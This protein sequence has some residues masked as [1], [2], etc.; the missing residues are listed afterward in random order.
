MSLRTLLTPIISS[1]MLSR[2]RLLAHRIK[3]ESARAKAGK[4]HVVRVYLQVDD[5]YSVLLAQVLPEFLRRYPVAVQLSLVSPPP[6]GAAPERD[7][8]VAYS[9]VDSQL[10]ARRHGLQFLDHG[11][12]PDAVCLQHAARQLLT[13]IERGQ[14]VAM[15]A[16][17]LLAAW[18]MPLD[19]ATLR[20][21]AETPLATEPALSSH[22]QAA[23]AERTRLGHY[24]GAT[25]HYEGEWY[26]GIDRL[27][28]LEARLEQLGL[29]LPED[30]QPGM[31]PRVVPW[32]PLIPP[33][34]DVQNP[35]KLPAGSP[36]IEF[37]LSFRSPY[38][39]IVAP[40]VFA[41]AERFGVQV[42][43]RFVLPMV[44][45][46][47]PVPKE[48][49]QYIVRDTA[50][51]AWLQGTDFGRLN[52]PVGK[53]TERG[54]SLIPWAE[55]QG[56]GREYVLAFMDLVW[57][58]GVDAGSNRGL[59]RIVRTAGLNWDEAK[60]ALHNDEWRARAE[61]NRS[62]LFE[63]GLWGVPSFRWGNVTAWGQDR[64]WVLE[65]AMLSSGGGS[66]GAQ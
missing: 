29:R 4:P 3:A 56:R 5:P 28:H 39:A 11:T 65:Q 16:P 30:P 33:H 51:E 59:A 12:Q 38:S 14:G 66:L 1:R 19:P 21:L 46:G 42:Q 32:G 7:K 54:L 20:E 26:W 23:D 64:L 49:R 52:D 36:P 6:E 60:A 37:F 9:R 2:D 62:L 22:Q 15:A 45:R 57:A 43:L 53:P 17:V 35:P 40:R 18:G 41:M 48:K 47:L 34:F 8:L 44:M 61:A 27:H 58:K 63:L 55:Q 24:L 50:R 31:S 13:A 25:L 10:L